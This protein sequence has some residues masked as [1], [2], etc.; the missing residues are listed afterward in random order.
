MKT[1]SESTK[2]KIDEPEKEED[3]EGQET[4]ASAENETT[5]ATEL[6]QAD[7]Q[8]EQEPISKYMLLDRLFKF[9]R[10]DETP[11]NPVLAG[12]F[13]K[14]LILLI[15]RKQKQIIPYIFGQDS[16]VLD[17]LLKHLY[18]KSVAEILNKLMNIVDT[19]FDG[20][21]AAQIQEKK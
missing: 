15:N 11:L 14:L 3:K 7:D 18:Q 10:T 1:A 13:C 4:S 9:I 16:D 21:L 12:Y 17:C 20:D 2:P 19:N 6:T 8:E 5:A